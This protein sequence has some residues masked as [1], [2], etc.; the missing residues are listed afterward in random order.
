MKHKFPSKKIFF[1]FSKKTNL[2][3]PIRFLSSD[4][5]KIA[6]VEEDIKK[7]FRNAVDLFYGKGTSPNKREAIKIF[8]SLAVLHEHS[9]SYQ[10][11]NFFFFYISTFKK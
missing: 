7:K 1:S 2:F 11:S 9:K 4:D 8:R 5:S 3:F 10:V 6:N